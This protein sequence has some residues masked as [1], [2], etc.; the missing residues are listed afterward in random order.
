MDY[1]NFFSKRTNLVTASFIRNILKAAKEPGVISFAGGLP[2]PQTFPTEE[3]QD[4]LAEVGKDKAAYQYDTTE[5]YAPLRKS[6]VEY[7]SKLGINADINNVLITTGSQQALFETAL[8]FLNRGD[9]AIVEEPTFIGGIGPFKLFGFESPNSDN[10][11]GIAMD[12]KGLLVD[13]LESRLMILKNKKWQMPKFVYTIPTFQNP[14]GITMCEKRRKKLLDLAHEYDFLI[15]EDDPYGR[16]SYEENVPKPIKSFDE[17]GRVVYLG[18]FSKIF[19]PGY[20]VAWVI[21]PTEIV[22]QM[23]K[24][25]QNIDLHT[26]TFGQM[27]IQRYMELG[28]LEKHI[29]EIIP[30]Y[31]EKRDI[32]LKSMDA[33]FDKGYSNWVKPKGGL[34]TW[35]TVQGVDTLALADLAVKK[36][37]V[38]FV[39][40]PAFY[41]H[42]DVGGDGMRINF[43]YPSNEQ[44]EEGVIRL[45][46]AIEEER[47]KAFEET[48][49][50]I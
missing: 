41:L 37:R 32:M 2:N 13:E 49:T 42:P 28:L 30:F 46:N 11:E 15:I 23:A 35:I 10:I 38:A 34:F 36:Y 6:V 20:R 18:T 47:K 50:M 5:G 48:P 25:K 44:I 45:A 27:V 7:M 4:I 31:Q 16:I 43:S 14:T 3:L 40:G 9:R 39:P 22:A 8:L 1:S 29:Q 26:E 19:A 12:D 17:E 33:H 24:L 21:A